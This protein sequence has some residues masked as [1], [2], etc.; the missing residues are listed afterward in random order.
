MFTPFLAER[1]GHVSKLAAVKR[2]AC[3]SEVI[4]VDMRR[5]KLY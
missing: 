1:R 3:R 2:R 5:S 4:I